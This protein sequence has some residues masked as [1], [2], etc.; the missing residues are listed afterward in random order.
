MSAFE[1]LTY[2]Y[3]TTFLPAMFISK[4][5]E[6]HTRSR[7]KGA[8][9]VLFATV[10]KIHNMKII[11]QFNSYSPAKRCLV[12]EQIRNYKPLFLWPSNKTTPETQEEPNKLLLN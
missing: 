9:A 12:Q 10:I 4:I 3:P 7:H 8:H 5:T 2:S 6:I 1:R 11:N